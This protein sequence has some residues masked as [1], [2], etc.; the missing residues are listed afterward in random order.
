MVCPDQV[1]RASRDLSL[2]VDSRSR[3]DLPIWRRTCRGDAD[4]GEIHARIGRNFQVPYLSPSGPEPALQNHLTCVS[5]VCLWALVALSARI[6]LRW[7]RQHGH[8][9]AILH[10]SI[11]DVTVYRSSGEMVNPSHL[12]KRRSCTSMYTSHFGNWKS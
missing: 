8:D 9:R 3:D 4:S 11:H 12:D 6:H 5:A 10:S 2:M 1:T 7:P